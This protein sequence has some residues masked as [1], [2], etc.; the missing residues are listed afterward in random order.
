MLSSLGIVPASF[1]LTFAL[2]FPTKAMQ[3][4]LPKR[5]KSLHALPSNL[6]VLL[7]P[8]PSPQLPWYSGDRAMGRV[9]TWHI[10]LSTHRRSMVQERLCA[11]IHIFS[12][13]V[14]QPSKGPHCLNTKI[15]DFLLSLFLSEWETP[16]Q[17]G[18]TEPI[19]LRVSSH[20]EMRS[21][22]SVREKGQQSF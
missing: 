11:V 18:N 6:K 10:R 17:Q 13:H 15:S 16:A 1:Y 20:R 19:T 3:L 14:T 22:L 4:T 8:S 21:L 12:D 5:P 7:P 9:S 2:P